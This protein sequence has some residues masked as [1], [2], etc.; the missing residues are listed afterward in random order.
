MGCPVLNVPCKGHSYCGT[1]A[2]KG[3]SMEDIEAC[4]VLGYIDF[5]AS[6]PDM[7]D[8]YLSFSKSSLTDSYDGTK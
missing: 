8:P 4:G 2:F 5:L 6:R 7:I 3:C 1:D